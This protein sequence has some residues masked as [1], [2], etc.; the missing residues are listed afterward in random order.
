M[1][2]ARS[3]FPSEQALS[4]PPV[5]VTSTEETS[6]FTTSQNASGG[7]LPPRAVVEAKEGE[8]GD[9]EGEAQNARARPESLSE[10]T[11]TDHLNRRLLSSYLHTTLRNAAAPN[12]EEEESSDSWNELY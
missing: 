5:L 6:A 2:K 8:E 10:L 4:S 11:L 3:S 7:E 12:D 1:N 9:V